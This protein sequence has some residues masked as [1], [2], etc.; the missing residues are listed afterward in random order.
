MWPEWLP[1]G[2]HGGVRGFADWLFW[3]PSFYYHAWRH[4]SPV[5]VPVRPCGRQQ[6]AAHEERALTK[7]VVSGAPLRR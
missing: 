3:V 7:I 5:V 1:F 2:L 4:F 6:A